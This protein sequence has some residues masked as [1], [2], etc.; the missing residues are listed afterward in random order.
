MAKTPSKNAWTRSINS[1]LRKQRQAFD[2]LRR[3]SNYDG[4]KP[5]VKNS[6][7]KRGKKIK[8]L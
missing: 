3:A 2:K 5:F 8:P 4:A 7:L 1:S 6:R